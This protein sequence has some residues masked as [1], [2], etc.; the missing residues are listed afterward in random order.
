MHSVCLLHRWGFW[1]QDPKQ[2][3]TPECTADHVSPY[4]KQ[5][6]YIKTIERIINFLLQ[7]ICV[8]WL[9][10]M[11]SLGFCY[12]LMQSTATD[13]LEILPLWKGF[14]CFS[15][16]F[17]FQLLLSVSK[18]WWFHCLC[19]CCTELLDI[20]MCSFSNAIHPSIYLSEQGTA[21]LI[22]SFGKYLSYSVRE[23]INITYVRVHSSGSR[24]PFKGLVCKIK[25]P[26]SRLHL[27]F[28]VTLCEQHRQLRHDT[29]NMNQISIFS[30]VSIYY[31]R[32]KKKS[33]CPARVQKGGARVQKGL[34]RLC[35][36]VRAS[37]LLQA[38]SE[39][40]CE[41]LIDKTDRVCGALTVLRTS[42]IWNRAL[43]LIKYMP[44]FI[45]KCNI[46]TC[47][48]SLY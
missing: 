35:T 42:R 34:E 20:E 31:P 40:W 25:G 27:A 13:Q 7:S 4:V 41:F 24:I 11:L 36:S 21:W 15:F 43:S 22:S 44:T 33:L 30:P 19:C 28:T 18:R 17:F 6:M 2:P 8:V 14:Q 39:S 12:N 9:I 47:T 1:M 38:K 10:Y 23:N 45:W 46:C 5:K 32:K 16:L 29:G 37:V 3:I 26:A 48:S